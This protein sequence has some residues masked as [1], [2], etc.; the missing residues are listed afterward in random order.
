M[1]YTTPA[2]LLAI[3][4][5]TLGASHFPAE[6]GNWWEFS[7][8]TYQ[9]GWGVSHRDSGTVRWDVVSVQYFITDPGQTE[10]TI[11]Q[12]R[13][14]VRSRTE[15][16]IWGDQH[17][18]VD[19]FDSLFD[20]PRVTTDTL[21]LRGVDGV[22]GLWFA[23]DSC[24]SF[25]LDPA[26]GTSGRGITLVAQTVPFGSDSIQATQVRPDGCRTGSDSILPFDCIEPRYYSTAEG[27]GPVAYMAR[28]PTCLMDAYWGEEWQLLDAHI[29]ATAVGPA[30]R[31]APARF[32]RGGAAE[33]Y[34][35]CG[36]R[37]PAR[38]VGAAGVVL[39]R[40]PGIGLRGVVV[41]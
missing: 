15:G 33:A 14:L 34:D 12:T 35:L 40:L 19:E 2:L 31:A 11:V 32:R 6:T 9:G 1:R 30:P 27:I 25:V 13:S 5:P 7:Y 22:N 24:W 3:V 36:R 18:V 39:Q 41:R 21:V 10:F 20:P 16:G 29:A 38:P 26:A 37:V 17:P 23:G 8:L 28:S 4:W